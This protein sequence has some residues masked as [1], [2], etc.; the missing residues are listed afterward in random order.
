MSA[1][2]KIG[3]D[4]FSLSSVVAAV[5]LCGVFYILV[6]REQTKV[7]DKGTASRCLKRKCG[8]TSKQKSHKK[9]QARLQATDFPMNDGM[10]SAWD[11][12]WHS[13]ASTGATVDFRLQDVLLWFKKNCCRQQQ[14][15]NFELL[16]SNE[17]NSRNE[18]SS[19]YRLVREAL[20]L[21]FQ[22]VICRTKLVFDCQRLYVEDCSSA[23]LSSQQAFSA[24]CLWHHRKFSLLLSHEARFR[25]RLTSSFQAEVLQL[26]R[27][28]T[29]FPKRINVLI[30]EEARTQH[31]VWKEELISRSTVF[32]KIEDERRCSYEA[33]QDS[34]FEMFLNFHKEMK[35]RVSI[36]RSSSKQRSRIFE[37][38][39]LHLHLHQFKT[40]ASWHEVLGAT[41]LAEFRGRVHIIRC[42]NLE[43]GL[44]HANFVENKRKVQDLY[45]C[46]SGIQ[47]SPSS[48]ESSVMGMSES[49]SPSPAAHSVRLVFDPKTVT[50]VDHWD[51][52]THNPPPYLEAP[53]PSTCGITEFNTSKRLKN[54]LWIP[55][56]NSPPPT[57]SCMSCP[58]LTVPVNYPAKRIF[59]SNLSDFSGF[60]HQCA[61]SDSMGLQNSHYCDVASSD[62]SVIYAQ[63]ISPSK[64]P[65]ILLDILDYSQ[66]CQLLAHSTPF[67]PALPRQFG[68]VLFHVPDSGTHDPYSLPGDSFSTLTSS[69]PIHD[70]DSQ[71]QQKEFFRTKYNLPEPPVAPLFEAPEFVS[72]LSAYATAFVPLRCCVGSVPASLPNN[73]AVTDSSVVPCISSGPSQSERALFIPSIHPK[74]LA[75]T[76]DFHAA[77]PPMSWAD[78]P[79]DEP[80]EFDSP[81][82]DIQPNIISEEVQSFQSRPDV[83]A[84]GWYV[85]DPYAPLKARGATSETTY[86]WPNR[87]HSPQQKHVIAACNLRFQSS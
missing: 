68:G 30:S 43:F 81:V 11:N 2:D 76:E 25:H 3:D 64:S 44:L 79:P 40:F 51:N 62:P 85:N 32:F 84:S 77:P 41:P 82:L 1:I 12:F 20:E 45:K 34:G 58:K 42:A 57:T 16:L 86:L 53:T 18:V 60:S 47:N 59:H 14:K 70:T 75:T 10:P 74:S 36:W 13:T 83:V 80:F 61:Y 33:S 67:R 29:E 69:S 49:P 9:T 37:Q 50:T 71:E 19:I 7:E 46:F 26:M 78:Y 24:C 31:R 72:R 48:S 63:P 27:F 8:N 21:D 15:T 54:I 39:L 23:Y 28:L 87:Q 35:E 52:D 73:A 56:S 55:A 38:F 4:S 6:F 5:L 22:E 65:E 66:N 17:L